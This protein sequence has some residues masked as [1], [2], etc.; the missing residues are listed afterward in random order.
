MGADKIAK[1]L[2]GALIAGLAALQV[3][4]VPDTYGVIE[5][6]PTEWVII[7]MAVVTAL[8]FVWG[9]PNASN[10]K[11]YDYYITKPPAPVPPAPA[12]APVGYA[13]PPQG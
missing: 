11:K 7:A 3:A 2:I 12:P 9:V 1:A 10:E 13:P 8:G 4:L 5:V 6:N